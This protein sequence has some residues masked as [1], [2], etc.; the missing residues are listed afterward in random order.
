[1]LVG[2]FYAAAIC[3]IFALI[4]ESHLDA[5]GKV[6]LR[7]RVS[8]RI[9]LL[10]ATAGNTANVAHACDVDNF[11]AWEHILIVTVAA[12]E[13]GDAAVFLEGVVCQFGTHFVSAYRH[14]DGE[15][16]VGVCFDDVVLAVHHYHAVNFEHNAFNRNFSAIIV[17]FT[18]YFERR[19]ISE[20]HGVALRF[21][22]Q[23]T[24][25][26][27][28]FEFVNAEAWNHHVGG[29]VAAIWQRAQRVRAVGVGV[30]A[31]AQLR[32]GWHVVFNECS[33]AHRTVILVVLGAFVR[34]VE[35]LSAY[36]VVECIVSIEACFVTNDVAAVVASNADAV[37]SHAPQTHVV[38]HTLEAFANLHLRVVVSHCCSAV[39]Y[40]LNGVVDVE[41]DFIGVSHC[42]DVN[43]RR[44]F[45]E[46]AHIVGCGYALRT[47]GEFKLVVE[48]FQSVH[49]RFFHN[50][51]VAFRLNPSF[52]G[53]IG[54]IFQ[55]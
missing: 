10:N 14:V 31:E 12:V 21:L 33:T 47:Y 24:Q 17:N 40:G 44:R 26:L 18:R 38:N 9:F 13:V 46:L 50:Y 23:Q 16:T 20:V 35:E 4:G 34:Y 55:H 51:A 6:V 27:F 42:R 11:D 19:F 52:E 45:G 8:Q 53:C 22:A 2:F 29:S 28:R 30:A 5:V 7:E 15:M 43:K 32:C 3:F 54:G 1:M 49:S 41:I 39:D 36:R 48:I 37:A 25:F